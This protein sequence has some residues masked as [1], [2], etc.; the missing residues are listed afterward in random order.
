MKKCISGIALA[1]ALSQFVSISSYAAVWKQDAKGWWVDNGDGTYKKN[2]WYKDNGKDY[3]LGA[4]G[5]MLTNTTTPDGYKVG[6]DGSWINEKAPLFDYQMDEYI[7][8]YV[9]HWIQ[10]NFSDEE[11]L[12]L[13]YEFSNKDQKPVTPGWSSIE[14]EAYQNG[15]Q[16]E[17][18][19]ISSSEISYPWDLSAKVQNGYSAKVYRAFK[20]KDRSP[21]SLY[22]RKHSWNDKFP[23]QTATLD[24]QK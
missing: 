19:G 23:T 7:V 14:I 18:T 5:Y 24:L 4:D 16:L 3:Y 2:E 15:V 22:V 20:L 11:S 8:K 21:V 1:I 10:E 6:A 12:V 17:T 13:L 9:D